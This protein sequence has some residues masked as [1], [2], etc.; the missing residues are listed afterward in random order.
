MLF[1]LYFNDEYFK[2]T[3]ILLKSLEKY[4][5]SSSVY[6]HGYNLTARQVKRLY[7]WNCVVDVVEDSIIEDPTV[8]IPHLKGKKIVYRPL[9]FQITC[10]KGHILLNAM[11]KFPDEK[12]Y[13]IMDVDMMFLKNVSKRL[14]KLMDNKD[15]GLTPTLTHHEGKMVGKVKGGFIVTNKNKRSLKFWKVYNSL[16]YDNRA[17]HYNKD[18]ICLYNSYKQVKARYLKLDGKEYMNPNAKNPSSILSAHKSIYGH[19]NM[20][21]YYYKKLLEKRTR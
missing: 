2:W 9:R 3:E 6:I 14:Y 19:K 4:E 15:I 17:L 10:G 5:P 1:I 12:L 8:A 21:F 11:K 18:Q 13:T 16:V 20:R 7:R